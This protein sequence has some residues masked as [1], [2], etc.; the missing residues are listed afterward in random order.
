[1]TRRPSSPILRRPPSRSLTCATIS[2]TNTFAGSLHAWDLIGGASFDLAFGGCH[3][4]HFRCVYSHALDSGCRYCCDSRNS[5]KRPAALVAALALPQSRYL[6]T[7][8]AESPGGNRST[9][10]NGCTRHC[11]TPRRMSSKGIWG[12]RQRCT[13]ERHEFFE[14]IGRAHV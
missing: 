10:K 3:G 2:A 12:S 14:E 11:S 7:Q 6:Q 1:M 13:G 5:R 8:F 4:T 9:T